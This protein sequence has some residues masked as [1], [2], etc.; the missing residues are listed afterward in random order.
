MVQGTV[1]NLELTRGLLVFTKTHLNSREQKK[2]AGESEAISDRL[3][4]ALG[5]VRETLQVGASLGG[6]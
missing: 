5:V 4:W 1:G 2:I 6:T 3:Q